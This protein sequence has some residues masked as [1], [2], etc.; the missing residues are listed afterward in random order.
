MKEKNFFK[1]EEAYG[2]ISQGPGLSLQL[3][4]TLHSCLS[5]HSL[6]QSTLQTTRRQGLLTQDQRPAVQ[7]QGNTKALSLKGLREIQ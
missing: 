5:L 7:T 1:L 6:V 4:S 3:S 2:L